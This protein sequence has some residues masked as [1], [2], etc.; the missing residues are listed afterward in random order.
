[1]GKNRRA[2]QARI[3]QASRPESVVLQASQFLWQEPYLSTEIPVRRTLRILYY[4]GYG[5]TG[6]YL[7]SLFDAS[8]RL[9][10][11][12]GGVG[13]WVLPLSLGAGLHS[14]SQHHKYLA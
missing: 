8:L 6:M 12:R 3:D 4:I 10:C 7:V 14:L 1:M 9:R 5:Y 13:T 11:P 2:V